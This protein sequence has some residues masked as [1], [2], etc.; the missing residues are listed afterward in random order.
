[1]FYQNSNHHKLTGKM[2]RS[3]FAKGIPKNM[4]YR[5]HRN[6]DNKTF[7][8]E[9]QKQLPSVSEFESFQFQF[10]VILNQCPPLKQKLIP[11][12]N[13]P[14]MPKPFVKLL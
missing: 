14:F 6:F 5:Y 12:N 13:K 4:F 2:L 8:E 9:L 10:K 3:T 11:N 1:M 7:E